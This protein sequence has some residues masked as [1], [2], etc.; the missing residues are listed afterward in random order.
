MTNGI[1]HGGKLN[2]RFE[3]DSFNLVPYTLEMVFKYY[4]VYCHSDYMSKILDFLGGMFFI[5]N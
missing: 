1:F 2:L 3:V 5:C 4:S